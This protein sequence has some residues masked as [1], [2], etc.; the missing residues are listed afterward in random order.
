MWF[1]RPRS[2]VWVLLGVGERRGISLSFFVCRTGSIE[3]DEWW[4]VWSAADHCGRLLAFL[5]FDPIILDITLLCL[6]PPFV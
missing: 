1:E 2:G 3:L 4:E 6:L 5:Y